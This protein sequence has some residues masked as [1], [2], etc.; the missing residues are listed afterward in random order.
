M[1]ATGDTVA[2]GEVDTVGPGTV[3]YCTMIRLERAIVHNRHV[4]IGL[5][6]AKRTEADNIVCVIF[7]HGLKYSYQV[8]FDFKMKLS[9]L[10]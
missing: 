7:L 8:L 9:C 3:Y 6:N 5:Q 1:E 4:S 2:T 10:L